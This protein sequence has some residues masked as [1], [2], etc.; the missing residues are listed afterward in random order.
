MTLRYAFR[1][2]AKS[3]GFVAIAVIALGVGLGLSTTMF[4]VMDA[5][6]HPYV[7][8]EH[9]ETLFGINWWFGKVHPPMTE[10]ELYRFIRD[11]THSFSAMVPEARWGEL[12]LHYPDG[13]QQIRVTRLSPRFFGVTGLAVARGRPFR[14]GD[15][16]DVAIVSPDVWHRL[17]GRRESLAGATATLGSA[18]YRVVGVMPE[19]ACDLCAWLPIDPGV[20]TTAA[21]VPGYFGLMV[22]LK[23]GVS[24]ASAQDE[25]TALAHE[26]S[27]RFGVQRSPYAFDLTPTVE[28]TESVRDIQKA[29]IGSALLVLLIACVNLAHLMLA[30]GLAKR[31]ELA[32]RMALGA[33]RGA[34]VRQMLLEC[35]IIT[36]TGA[37]LG[38][39]ITLWAPTCCG[40]ACLTRCRGS[41]WCAR[42]CRGV[43]SHCR[44]ALPR[45]RRSCSAWCPPC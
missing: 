17:Y 40:T 6:L 11:H 7:P 3:P 24:R 36:A 9:T 30:R 2:L 14:G 16:E 10:P 27:D 5:V 19:G 21:T 29:M 13:E 28:A 1:S 23:P 44:R 20:E 45:R 37:A 38:L 18:V 22:R 43:C 25:L 31:R 12:T 39:A 34:V 32:V 42:N 35:A 15:G 4:A 41:A 26:L 33:S 8:Y